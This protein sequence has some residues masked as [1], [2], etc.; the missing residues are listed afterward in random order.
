ME[1]KHVIISEFSPNDLLGQRFFNKPEE[2]LVQEQG[3]S[4]LQLIIENNLILSDKLMVIGHILNF[5]NSRNALLKSGIYDYE[6]IIVPSSKNTAADFAFA[7]FESNPNDILLITNASF[8]IQ[9]N[10]YCRNTIEQAKKLAEN[11]ELVIIDFYH[12]EFS[13]LGNIKSI[14]ISKMY[15]FMAKSFLEELLEFEPI[16]YNSVKR[17]HF[18]KS[19]SFINELLN[20]LIPNQ[21]AENAVFKRSGK[22]KAI[23]A[24]FSEKI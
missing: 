9:V 7:A 23:N 21:T 4:P 2:Y 17:A 14:P 5:K 11:G 24:L 10:D 12:E 15:C 6:E 19:G 1:T 16:I 3:K 20:E 13:N 18:K 22:V 8:F